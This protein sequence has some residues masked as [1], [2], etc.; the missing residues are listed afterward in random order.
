MNEQMSAKDALK[1]LTQGLEGKNYEKIGKAICVAMNSLV[2]TIADEREEAEKPKR[3]SLEKQEHVVRD[4]AHLCTHPPNED[5]CSTAADTL[6]TLREDVVP[7]MKLIA[8]KEERYPSVRGDD[9]YAFLRK[10]GVDG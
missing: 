7:W 9:V 8:A 5:V 6:K 2:K 3:P 10:L 4:L 1:V